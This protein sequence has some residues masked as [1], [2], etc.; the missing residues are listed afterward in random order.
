[1]FNYVVIALCAS[2]LLYG[3]N[4]AR[5]AINA[6]NGRTEAA[7]RAMQ[8]YSQRIA[9]LEEIDQQHTQ[10]MRATHEENQRLITD[11]AAANRRLSIR[12]APVSTPA[13]T[14]M[15]DGAGTRQDIHPE[16]AAAIVRITTDAD[17]CRDKLTG[18]QAVIRAHNER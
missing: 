8:S 18:L 14:C 4:G 5:T 1:M 17:M 2:V 13:N 7:E 10:R 12:T 3:W 11:L 16:D 6:A 15:D 9:K